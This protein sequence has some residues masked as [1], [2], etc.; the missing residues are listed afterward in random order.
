[1]NT[2]TNTAQAPVLAKPGWWTADL[3]VWEDLDRLRQLYALSQ[4]H[5][6]LLSARGMTFWVKR[7]E[8]EFRALFPDQCYGYE[9]DPDA[10]D[11]W[12]VETANQEDDR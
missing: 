2:T 3:S 1:M 11:A 10:F 9:V 7:K 12:L 8:E 6:E 4:G 5:L